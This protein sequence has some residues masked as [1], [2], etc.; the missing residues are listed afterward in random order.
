[1]TPD[2]RKLARHALGLPNGSRQ[3]YRNRF[4]AGPKSDVGNHREWKEMVRRGWAIHE[5][6][7]LFRLTRAGAL[8]A[9]EPDESLDPEDFPKPP[10]AA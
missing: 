3:T 1:M 10:R 2:Q 5:P 7:S 4:F 9:L 6:P 8:M